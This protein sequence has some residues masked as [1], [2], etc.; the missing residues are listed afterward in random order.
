MLT[1]NTCREEAEDDEDTIDEAGLGHCMLWGAERNPY[2]SMRTWR[3]S[4]VLP[5]ANNSSSPAPVLPPVPP[6]LL[7]GDEEEDANE[8]TEA[9]KDKAEEGSGSESGSSSKSEEEVLTSNQAWLCFGPAV[10]ARGAV[11]SDGDQ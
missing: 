3:W 1:I 4:E 8:E 10:V 5:P 2:G 7:V 11:K 9:D 6:E